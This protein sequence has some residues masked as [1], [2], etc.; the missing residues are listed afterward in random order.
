MP[1]R[2]SDTCLE[3]LA[4]GCDVSVLMPAYNE[5]ENLAEVIPAGRAVLERLGEQLGDRRRRRR[6]HRRHPHGHGAA[7]AAPTSATS[8]CAATPGSRPAL[9][10]GLEHVEG[11]YIVLMDADGQD[12]PAELPRLLATLETAARPASPAAGPSA[13]TGSS[14]ATPR[15][16]T[17]A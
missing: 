13:T 1:L 4:V 8:G 11:E 3:V 10:V 17:T 12:D 2:L 6:Q 9:S 15:S 7:C 14:S 5:A 16:S